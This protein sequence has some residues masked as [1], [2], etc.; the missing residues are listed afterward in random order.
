MSRNVLGFIN[1]DAGL[2][3]STVIDDS[4]NADTLFGGVPLLKNR[5]KGGNDQDGGFG[6]PD[7]RGAMAFDIGTGTHLEMAQGFTARTKAYITY[8]SKVRWTELDDGASCYTFVSDGDAPTSPANGSV[9]IGFS[10]GIVTASKLMGQL[11]ERIG[12]S[13]IPFGVTG[14][15][16]TMPVDYEYWALEVQHNGAS[17]RARILRTS[18]SNWAEYV[19]WTDMTTT[20]PITDS[21]F[22]LSGDSSSAKGSLS[23]RAVNQITIERDEA[24]VLASNPDN[25]LLTWAA[26]SRYPTSDVSSAWT[27]T[28]SCDGTAW[29]TVDDVED[30]ADVVDDYLS[31]SSANATECEIGD[32]EGATDIQ[33]VFIVVVTE[34]DVSSP[35]AHQGPIRI[36]ARIGAGTIQYYT[37]YVQGRQAASSAYTTLYKWLPLDPHGAAWTLTNFNSLRVGID[38]NSVPSAQRNVYG[39]QVGAL[40]AGWARPT[41]ASGC[42]PTLGWRMTT[43]SVGLIIVDK[44]IGY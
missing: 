16:L 10:G 11:Y 29:R 3:R 31:S 28:G 33:G 27:V 23:G 22:S 4:P 30:T 18:G 13:W 44:I 36:S 37:D 14:A 5:S 24:I 1:F 8:I 20:A 6:N 43:D 32:H 34:T 39:I 21:V 40:G 35:F 19:G 17:S 12:G 38:N 41:K 9:C 7:A 25:D 2:W 15:E 26:H 42:P